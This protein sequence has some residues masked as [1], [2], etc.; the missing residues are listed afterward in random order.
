MK[1]SKADKNGHTRWIVGSWSQLTCRSID[2]DRMKKKFK[3]AKNKCIFEWPPTIKLCSRYELP[4]PK[5]K[6]MV[7]R[8]MFI[9]WKAQDIKLSHTEHLTEQPIFNSS[10][11][12][13][14]AMHKKKKRQELLTWNKPQN[15]RNYCKE[16]ETC[17]CRLPKSPPRDSSS[18]T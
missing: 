5:T 14:T 11:P 15:P 13:V 6:K 17:D 1:Q 18:E 3:V 2:K 8:R 4:K 10:R 7:Q 16:V 9:A 12:I